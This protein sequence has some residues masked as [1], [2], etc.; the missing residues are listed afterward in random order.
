MGNNIY[1]QLPLNPTNVIYKTVFQENGVDYAKSINGVFSLRR[2]NA[3]HFGN[4]FSS[5][6]KL[7][8]IR[9]QSVK[10]S[11]ENY[12]KWLLGEDF[13][14]VEVERRAWIITIL[15]SKK[16]VGK[17]IVYYKRLGEPSHADALDY[18]IN[19]HDWN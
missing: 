2:L 4:P 13:T 8:L 1:A 19:C 15:K 16:L 5:D 7:K 11:V 6:K 3:Y 9:T 18:F 17:P 14:D 10:E 12:I